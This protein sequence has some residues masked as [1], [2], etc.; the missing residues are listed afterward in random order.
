M[1]NQGVNSSVRARQE[2]EG[3][4]PSVRKPEVSEIFFRGGEKTVF[5]VLG[6]LLI[7]ALL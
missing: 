1:G 6:K 5:P 3:K 2:S 4:M 7:L